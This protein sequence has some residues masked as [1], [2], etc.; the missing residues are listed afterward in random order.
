M[1][2]DGDHHDMSD[3]QSQS[4]EIVL[5]NANILLQ[6]DNI[7]LYVDLIDDHKFIY[8]RSSGD[9]IFEDSLSELE[10]SS[11]I[12]TAA[13]TVRDDLTDDERLWNLQHQHNYGYNRRTNK[14]STHIEDVTISS[15]ERM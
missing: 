6:I 11:L 8:V 9:A 7:L 5:S 10:T 14:F 12:P 15:I 1:D 2:T 4:S 13:T 3:K